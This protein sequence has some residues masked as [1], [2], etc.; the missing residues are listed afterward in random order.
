MTPP[1]E[2]ALESLAQGESSAEIQEPADTVTQEE[3]TKALPLPLPLQ[4]ELPV[5]TQSLEEEQ[6]HS[7]PGN[8]RL[9]GQ[10]T[11]GAL[12]T[13]PPSH[14]LS[15]DEGQSDGVSIPLRQLQIAVGTIPVVLLSATAV[16]YR[17]R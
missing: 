12:E 4:L 11:G 15:E 2:V 1:P 5:V 8:P 6:V 16:M 10:G 9:L 14:D 13:A 7:L 3:L 17:R